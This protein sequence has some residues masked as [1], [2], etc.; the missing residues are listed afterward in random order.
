ME[1]KMETKLKHLS[2]L[3]GALLLPLAM[4][5]GAASCTLNDSV[6]AV[7]LYESTG[8]QEAGRRESYYRNPDEPGIVMKFDS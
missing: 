5:A 6:N 1:Q 2:Y 8:F 4:D 3:I 7:K